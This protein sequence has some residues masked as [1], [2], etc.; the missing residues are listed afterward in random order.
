MSSQSGSRRQ[1]FTLPN[2]PTSG[3]QHCQD[4]SVSE[5]VSNISSPDYRDDYDENSVGIRDCCMEISDHSDSDSTL[6]VSE[7]RQ[8]HVRVHGNTTA[9]G[10]NNGEGDHRI[11]IQVKGP[12]KDRSGKI[13]SIGNNNVGAATSLRNDYLNYQVKYH[14]R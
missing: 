5:A 7:P 6:L 13:V 8:R 2:G 11:V 3:N 4:Y 9:G 12:E 14:D 1:P 10:V